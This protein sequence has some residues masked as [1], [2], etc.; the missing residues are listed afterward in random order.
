MMIDEAV[1]THGGTDRTY[2]VC[3]C[4]HCL[5]EAVCSPTDDFYTTDGPYPGA[6]TSPLFC[7]SCVLTV[8]RLPGLRAD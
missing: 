2:R 5:V 8:H 6:T 1:V 3:R 4:S 7:K